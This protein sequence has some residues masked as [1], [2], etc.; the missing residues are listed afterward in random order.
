[1]TT[2]LSAVSGGSSL[3]PEVLAGV[4]EKLS[5]SIFGKVLQD[6]AM[7]DIKLTMWIPSDLGE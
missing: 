2:G 6:Y 5:N 4:D 3:S 7:G 1:M